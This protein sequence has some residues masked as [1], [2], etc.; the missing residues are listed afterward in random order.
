M[1]QGKIM[2]GFRVNHLCHLGLSIALIIGS[3]L[4]IQVAKAAERFVG[5][6]TKNDTARK[7]IEID[8]NIYDVSPQLVARQSGPMAFARK[9]ADIK[10]GQSVMLETEKG[11]VTSI[12]LIEGAVPE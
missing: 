8:G 7:N 12:T 2:S 5:E 1:T 4:H 10:P 6:V 11:V 3:V 9:V